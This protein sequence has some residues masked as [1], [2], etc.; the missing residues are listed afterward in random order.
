MIT[1][2]SL[3]HELSLE[4]HIGSVSERKLLEFTTIS[5]GTRFAVETLHHRKEAGEEARKKDRS[6][7]SH[8]LFDLL[9]FSHTK[10]NTCYGD[11]NTSKATAAR[12][13]FR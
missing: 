12:N 11:D 1:K 7:S 5:I 10:H 2:V 9:L 13:S 4:S 6:E 8:L 3:C